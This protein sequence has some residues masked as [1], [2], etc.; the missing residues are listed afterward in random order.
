MDG[1][2]EGFERTL[3]G[4][5]TRNDIWNRP[6]TYANLPDMGHPIENVCFV[7]FFF[8]LLIGG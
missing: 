5:G 4:D 7:W 8:L 2:E 6:V 1:K 3:Q